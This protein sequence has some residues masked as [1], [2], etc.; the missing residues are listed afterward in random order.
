[1]RG[2]V[3]NDP[4]TTFGLLLRACVSDDKDSRASLF[5][6]TAVSF[7]LGMVASIATTYFLGA[8]HLIV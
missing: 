8:A 6:A 3:A 4:M 1:M 5:A 2:S 7:G